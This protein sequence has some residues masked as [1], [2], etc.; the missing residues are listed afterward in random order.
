ML[1][2][3]KGRVDQFRHD[4]EAVFGVTRRG[5]WVQVMFRF[6]AAITQLVAQHAESAEG[7]QLAVGGVGIDLTK[8]G[9]DPFEKLLFGALRVEF[10]VFLPLINLGFLDK[11]STSSAYRASSRL[12]P[13]AVPSCQPLATTWVMMSFWKIC[14]LDLFYMVIL[15]FQQFDHPVEVIFKQPI[16]HNPVFFELA[17]CMGLG[18]LCG[19]FSCVLKN[20]PV[21]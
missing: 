21:P 4:A 19:H 13:T 9:G 17:F 1:V 3:D 10:A 5:I 12:Y 6:D 14:S 2:A 7:A 20:F 11:P 18:Q 8:L 16:L 15:P